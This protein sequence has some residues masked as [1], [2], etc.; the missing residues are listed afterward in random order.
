MAA[1]YEIGIA[2]HIVSRAIL[3]VVVATLCV[4]F[5]IRAAIARHY[6]VGRHCNECWRSKLLC[7]Y[8]LRTARNTNTGKVCERR[9]RH[10]SRV[11]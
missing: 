7:D 10:G 3:V 11:S 4:P 8:V 2:L 9:L 1:A 5:L 6:A